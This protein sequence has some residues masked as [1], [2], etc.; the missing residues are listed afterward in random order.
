MTSDY[1]NTPVSSSFTG[2]T[3]DS[4]AYKQRLM[5]STSPFRYQMELAKYESCSKCFQAYPGFQGTLGGRG[6]SVGPRR[7]D[8]DSDLRGQTRLLSRCPQKKYN[9]FSYKHCQQCN[10]CNTGLPCGCSHCQSRD[11]DALNDCRPG[12]VPMESQD[13]RT[14]NACN[15]LNGLFINR[16]DHVCEN[17]QDPGRWEF[18]RS[19][20][21]LGEET[22]LDNRDSYPMNPS[23]GRYMDCPG[24]GVQDCKSPSLDNMNPCRKRSNGGCR[25]M[26]DF[27]KNI[28]I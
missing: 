26:N 15:P 12:I 28:I 27:A 2:L 17:P 9:P 20:R 6:P 11:I 5:E 21:R 18:Y 13:T 23:N 25:H 10:N 1:K 7:I 22:R 14:F 3:D 16:F 4:C 19:N 24:T 8:M